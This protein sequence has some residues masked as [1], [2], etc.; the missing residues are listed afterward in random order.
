M[1]SGDHGANE[2]NDANGDH[3]A[4]EEIEINFIT[5]MFTISLDCANSAFT[6]FEI[7]VRVQNYPICGLVCNT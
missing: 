5:C 2:N 1:G 6:T 7:P 3:E 4:N